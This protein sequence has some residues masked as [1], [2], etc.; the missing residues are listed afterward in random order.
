MAG[1]I[2]I[3]GHVANLTRSFN[4][5]VQKTATDIAALSGTLRQV[6]TAHNQLDKALEQLAAR[7]VAV[8]QG[9][10]QI[11]AMLQGVGA[12]NGQPVPAVQTVDG[13]VTQVSPP[14]AQQGPPVSAN[15]VPMPEVTQLSPEDQAIFFSGGE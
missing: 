10:R 7:Q 13:Q 1:P 6:V 14:A 9:L 3:V 12:V 15:G 2:D 11:A 8:E 4:A 5:F